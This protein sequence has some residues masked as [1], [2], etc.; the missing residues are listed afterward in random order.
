MNASTPSHTE[1]WT[2]RGLAPTTAR[3]IPASP[4]RSSSAATTIAAANSSNMT[5]QS[6]A[7]L[8]LPASQVRE[9]REAFSLLDR[10]DDGL[11]NRDDVVDVLTNLGKT[12]NGYSLTLPLAHY[13]Q[14]NLPTFHPYHLS[15]L[16]ALRKPNPCLFFSRHCHP[17]SRP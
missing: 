14:A 3:E 13:C 12:P 11:V 17:S 4:T 1:S 15:S 2:P 16:P 8:Q 10:N 5:R 9:M 6:D 7:L